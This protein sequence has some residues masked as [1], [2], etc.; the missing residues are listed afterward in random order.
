MRRLRGVW[1]KKDLRRKK[2]LRAR[3]SISTRSPLCS[4]ML[5]QERKP[6]ATKATAMP[7]LQLMPAFRTR[8]ALQA[9][10][11]VRKLTTGL[12][13]LTWKPSPEPQSTPES[14]N[15]LSFLA[16]NLVLV[17][18][19]CCIN[20]LMN[21]WKQQYGTALADV[22]I[23]ASLVAFTLRL[24]LTQFHQ[25]QEI[26][27]RKAAQKQLTASNEQISHLLDNAR[28]QT[29]EITQISELGSLL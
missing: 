29:A 7:W 23:A 17:A 10:A 11:M 4:K 3:S 28:R 20:L 16:I 6:H 12:I 26:A 9:H 25:Q 14:P 22:A 27:G 1:C 21:R 5:A 24:A 15:F 19:L 13:A 2:C 8:N 18:M